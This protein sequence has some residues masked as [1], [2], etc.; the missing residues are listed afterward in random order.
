MSQTLFEMLEIF[1]SKKYVYRQKPAV[2]ELT[3]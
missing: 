2:M 3:S 1:T